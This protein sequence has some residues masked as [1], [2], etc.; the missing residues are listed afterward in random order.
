[1]PAVGCEKFTDELAARG[2]M[3]FGIEGMVGMTTKLDC[4][5]PPP[6]KSLALSKFDC[7]WKFMMRASSVLTIRFQKFVVQARVG[8]VVDVGESNE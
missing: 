8:A 7:A 1:M 4:I 6:T 3:S 5:F 2:C